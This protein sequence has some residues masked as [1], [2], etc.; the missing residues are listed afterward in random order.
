LLIIADVKY[1]GNLQAASTL[2]GWVMDM[3]GYL[4]SVY[5]VIKMLLCAKAALFGEDFSSDPAS[6]GLS[7]LLLVT[8][9][10]KLHINLQVCCTLLSMCQFDVPVSFTVV[11]RYS[12]FFCALKKLDY[13]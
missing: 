8:S 3:L 6:R 11:P 10:G 2:L 12:R 4:L 13:K 5:C 1:G 7:L 9:R